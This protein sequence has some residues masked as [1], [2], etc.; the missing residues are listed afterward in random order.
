MDGTGDLFDD[1]ISALP[2]EFGVVAVRYPV[3]QPL[4]YAD[5]LPFIRDASSPSEPFAMI[6]ESFST[7]LA[8]QYAAAQ[9]QNLSCLIMCAGFVTSPATGWKRVVA[10]LLAPA[11]FK[12]A[13]PEHLIRALLLDTH[14]PP[15][16]VLRVRQAISS[17]RADVL[18]S[19]LR[20]ILAC[21]VRTEL[22]KVT[23]PL[24]YIQARNDRLV[25]ASNFA[26][27]KAIRPNTSVIVL[28]AP[29]LLLQRNPSGAARAVVD[30]VRQQDSK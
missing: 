15:D 21:D 18:C 24:L 14:A 25:R 20:E 29:H 23:T 30:F 8:I 16:L 13:M 19:R 22:A 26:T 4:R 17:V 5:L 1:F 3:E 9:S 28:D 10:S 27:I 6:A 11:T 7:P 2:S 12:R